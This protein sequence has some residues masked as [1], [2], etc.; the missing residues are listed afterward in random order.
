MRLLL[1]AVLVGGSL[2]C[3]N[4]L[5]TL[6]QEVT[7]GAI[8]LSTDVHD[9]CNSQ[10]GS[11]TS[12]HAPQYKQ[13]IN[14]ALRLAF[15]YMSISSHFGRDT[16]HR[17]GF[18]KLFRSASDARFEQ[19]KEMIKYVVKRGGHMRGALNV[20]VPAT[21]RR[22]TPLPLPSLGLALADA[23]DMYAEQARL[24]R[25]ALCLTSEAGGLA[26]TGCALDA[27]LAHQAQDALGDEVEKVNDLARKANQLAAMFTSE[28]RSLAEHMFDQR[29]LK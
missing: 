17:L 15:E 12:V 2:A 16:N 1:L 5:E 28:E 11:F 7:G 24:H 22:L 6:V 19:A 21:P 26:D 4:R 20:E 29:L 14:N 10:V 18:Q 25:G 13:V 23:K 8:D 3:E 9:E 27:D